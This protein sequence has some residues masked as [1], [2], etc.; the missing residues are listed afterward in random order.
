VRR[1][2]D[3]R[4]AD[5]ERLDEHICGAGLPPDVYKI[6]QELFRFAHEL[7]VAREEAEAAGL[8]AASAP[9]SGEIGDLTEAFQRAYGSG[10][11]AIV[12]NVPPR[13]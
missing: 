7:A 11:R 8:V 12:G 10:C 1:A 13:R 6:W 9:V 4:V 2:F 3:F 5:L